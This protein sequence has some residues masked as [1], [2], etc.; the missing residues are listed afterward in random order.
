MASKSQPDDLSVDELEQILFRK[1][2]ARRQQRLRRLKDEGRLVQVAGLTSPFDRE[3]DSPNDDQPA[4]RGTSENET[5]IDQIIT[6][7][8]EDG[9][10]RPIQ[11]RWIANKILLF[12][13]IGAVVGL[14]I[15]GFPI[16]VYFTGAEPGDRP[17]AAG[18][19]WERSLAD[20]LSC[21]HYRCGRLTKWTQAAD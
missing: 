8:E 20:R 14:V 4:T 17:G 11:W 1:K 3:D 6:S 12:F 2:R 9:G 13:E 5:G 16:M 15:S 7:G 19:E 10:K 21:P 18:S